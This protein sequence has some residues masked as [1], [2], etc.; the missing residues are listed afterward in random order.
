MAAGGEMAR[1]GELLL[2]ESQDAP[3]RKDKSGGEKTRRGKNIICKALL[4]TDSLNKSHQLKIMI[5]AP[6][7]RH[8]INDKGLK[9]ITRYTLPYL[10]IVSL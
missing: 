7:I 8:I 4:K 10:Y 5:Y 3:L 9:V 2:G 1:G 6:A